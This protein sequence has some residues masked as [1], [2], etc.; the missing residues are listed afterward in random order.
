MPKVSVILPCYNV[1]E[2]IDKCMDSLLNQTLSDVEFIFVDDCSTDNTY[3]QIK[4]YTDPRIKLI[5]H[6]VNRYT[7][8]ARNTG[9]NNATGEYL[10]FIDPDDYIEY[11]FLEKLYD[12][13]KMNNADIA[14]GIMR[15]I[16]SGKLVSKN[17]AINQNK[18]NFHFM[19]QTAIY[20]KEMIDKHHI[21]FYVDV[22]CG[23]FP[24]IYYAN[25]IVTCEDAIYNY[26]I[27]P[28]SCITSGF[29]IEK[30]QKLN[31][32]GAILTLDFINKHGILKNDCVKIL[33]PFL[34]RLSTY[35]YKRLSK[36]DKIKA[37][38][39]LNSYLDNFWNNI[40]YKDNEKFNKHF[41]EM[42]IKY[43]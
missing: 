21:R 7:A 29:T 22:I 24:M 34:L 25:K 17:Q 36:K 6:K 16:P 23:Q 5:H 1:S 14:K 8:E 11:D 28:N 2:Y 38:P 39:I 15:Y 26:V 10:A 42:R 35:G 31:L 33:Y 9:I 40:L 12:L 3:N 27:R 4:K 20:K 37:K 13:A 41:F 19:H 18:Y 43:A 30:W 32:K